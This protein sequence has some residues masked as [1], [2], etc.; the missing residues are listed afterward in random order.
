MP[1]HCTAANSCTALFSLRCLQFIT[2]TP[3]TQFM[4]TKAILVS[5]TCRDGVLFEADPGVWT[6]R[7]LTPLFLAWPKE[8]LVWSGQVTV[9]CWIAVRGSHVSPRVPVP[10]ERGTSGGVRVLAASLPFPCILPG[11]RVCFT[12]GHLA[13]VSAPGASFQP[14]SVTYFL[15]RHSSGACFFVS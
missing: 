3:P 9:Q 15:W 4:L 2:V 6:C 13:C 8:C 12:S 1:R 7:G 5:H 10:G 11:V 14:L